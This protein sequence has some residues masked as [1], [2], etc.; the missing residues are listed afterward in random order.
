[1]VTEPH[2]T[3]AVE[4]VKELG[5]VDDALWSKQEGMV[6]EQAE[7]VLLSLSETQFAEYENKGFFRDVQYRWT[8]SDGVYSVY[9][10]R[11]S[12]AKFTENMD[13][14]GNELEIYS[15]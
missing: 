14:S 10:A 5:E 6:E 2:I 13:S 1:M 9:I 15:E 7:E 4:E 3:V 11:G 8:F 12:Y